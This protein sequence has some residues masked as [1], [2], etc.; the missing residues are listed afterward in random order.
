MSLKLFRKIMRGETPASAPRLASFTLLEMLVAT[1]VFSMMSVLLF[2]IINDATKL[3][4]DQQSREDGFREARA[5]LNFLSRDIQASLISTNPNWFYT[6]SNRV[7][8]L[9]TLP[10]NS[11]GTGLDRGD[12]CAVGYSLEWGKMNTNS[13]SEKSRMSLYRYVRFS[14]P[15]YSTFV[16]VSSPIQ[17]LFDNPD[18][19]N[20]VRELLAANVSG[21]AFK[22]YKTNSAGIPQ[23]YT[24]GAGTPAIFDIVITVLN[25]KTAK[26]LNTQADWANTNSPVVRQNLQS[27][28]LRV[29]PQTP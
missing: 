4:R 28:A 5:A 21:V 16:R 25:D 18:G 29:R 23:T 10:S 22:F 1:A 26:Q 24:G 19:T 6:T 8:F 20:T 12:I 14:D 17:T 2:S 13:V 9:T 15:T 7:A 11:Q 27:F 3:W